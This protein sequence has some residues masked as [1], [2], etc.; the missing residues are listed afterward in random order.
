[1]KQIFNEFGLGNF[2]IK[3]TSDVNQEKES[4]SDLK[5]AKIRLDVNQSLKDFESQLHIPIFKPYSDEKDAYDV[6]LTTTE[7]LF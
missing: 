5:E 3:I 6:F 2:S 4:D 7:R 1:M